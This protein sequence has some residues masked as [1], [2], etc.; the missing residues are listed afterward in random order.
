MHFPIDGH[1]ELLQFFRIKIIIAI[2]AKVPFWGKAKASI[3]VG[4]G[5]HLACKTTVVRFD[6]LREI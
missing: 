4:T 3:K 6:C 2:Y 5:P 1:A